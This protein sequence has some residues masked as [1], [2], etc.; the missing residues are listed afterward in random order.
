MPFPLAHPA[1]VLP[2]RR[3][4][5]RFLSF[6]ALIVGSLS[7]DAGYFFSQFQ[8]DD[9]SHRLAGSI[10][11]CLPMGIMTLLLLYSIRTRIV[12]VLPNPLRR[13]FSPLCQQPLGSP[14]SVVLSV[15]IGAVMHILWDSF[16]HNE[17]WLVQH[18]SFLQFPVARITN[19]QVRICH[20]FWHGSTFAGVTWIVLAFQHWLQVTILFAAPA[21]FRVKLRNAF[22]FAALVLP[23][24]AA[25]HLFHL[26][27]GNYLVAVISV[28]L[29][30]GFVCWAA[31]QPTELV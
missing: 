25:H 26:T 17:G 21:T 15:V 2:F 5:P 9:F 30:I 24:A 8:V 18:L 12:M 3:Y 20:L 11:F 10:G 23:I 4:C 16:T 28:L 27:V 22:V 6:P 29:V 14:L 31:K 19:R 13:M 1:A 7:P